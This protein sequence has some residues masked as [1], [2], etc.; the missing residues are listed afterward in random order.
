MVDKTAKMPHNLL[1]MNENKE[2][3]IVDALLEVAFFFYLVFNTPLFLIRISRNSVCQMI[4][5]FTLGR[6]R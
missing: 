5:M 1:M 3:P 4:D 6:I 2:Y